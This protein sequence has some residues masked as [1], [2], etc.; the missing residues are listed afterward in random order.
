MLARLDDPRKLEMF[1]LWGAMMHRLADLLAE[2]WTRS[3]FDRATMVGRRRID[4]TAWNQLARAWNQVRAGWMAMA[5]AI[6]AAHLLDRVCP[7]KAMRLVGRDFADWHQSVGPAIEPDTRV[8]VELPLPWQVWRGEV[9]C[10]RAEVERACARAGV[11]PV[12]SGWTASR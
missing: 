12:A 2:V 6:G 5:H 11:D 7:G 1:G 4:S 10:G 9:V 8:W 3:S